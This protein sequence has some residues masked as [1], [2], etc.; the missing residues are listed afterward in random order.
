MF[1]QQTDLFK[2]MS[3]SFMEEL[4]KFIVTGD[5]KKGDYLFKAGEPAHHF[6]VLQQGRVRIIVGS[7][8]HTITMASNPGESFGW[9]CLVGFDSYTA[10]AECL[11]PCTLA[12]IEKDKLSALLEKDPASGL[13]FYKRLAFAIGQRLVNTYNMLLAGQAES[14]V[15]SY[16]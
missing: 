11:M 7:A 3:K 9:S 15:P 14:K 1:I 4:N 8:G 16:G 6:Y 5:Y 10:T 13:L 12:K 2:G